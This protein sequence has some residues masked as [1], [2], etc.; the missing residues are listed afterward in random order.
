MFLPR[1]PIVVSASGDDGITIVCLHC[2]REQ[3]VARR[4]LTVVCKH[5]HKSLRL[6]DIPIR[7]YQARR[8]IETLGMV[9]V[10]KKG[11]VVTEHVLCGGIVVRGKVKGNIR[12]Q[13][14]VLIGPEAEIKGDVTAP[15][16]AVGAG[17][18]LQ[19]RYHVGYPSETADSAKDES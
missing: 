6:E 19:G 9:T 18:V 13:G 3:T 17:A 7:D 4:A 16:L 10:E 8:N 1:E 2:R 12:S 11:H 14:S 15:A 5:C